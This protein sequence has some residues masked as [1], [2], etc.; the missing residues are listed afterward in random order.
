VKANTSTNPMHLP[1]LPSIVSLQ[2]LRM[3]R[4]H[5]MQMTKGM[6]H[7]QEAPLECLELL[8]LVLHLQDAALAGWVIDPG[9]VAE[10][11]GTHRLCVE[12]R[13]LL[14]RE[15]QSENVRQWVGGGQAQH[16]GPGVREG[17]G[18]RWWQRQRWQHVLDWGGEGGMMVAGTGVAEAEGAHRL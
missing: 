4:D 12:V 10:A 15:V 16:V 14:T 2:Q 9:V 8:Y 1:M 18:E 7:P 3:S 6:T 17:R 11:E 13:M 5:E